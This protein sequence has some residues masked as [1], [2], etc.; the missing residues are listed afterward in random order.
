M[1]YTASSGLQEAIDIARAADCNGY[2][3]FWMSEHHSMPGL[4]ISSPTVM[5]AR[6]IGETTRIRLGAGG[7]MLPNHSPLLVAEEYGMLDALA[8]GRIDLG[9]GRSA[10]PNP[11]AAAALGRKKDANETFPDQISELVGFLNNSF[12][13]GHV[14]EDV[15]AVPG[16]WQAQENRVAASETTPE[17]WL[18]GS[19]TNSARMAAQMGHSYAFAL[20]FGDADIEAAMDVY[21]EEFQPSHALMQPYSMVSVRATIADDEETARREATSSAVAMMRMQTRKSFIVPSPE[22]TQE[23]P[24]TADEQAIID[25]HMSRTLMGTP[26]SVA[27]QIEELQERSGVDE[28]MLVLRSYTPGADARGIELLASHYGMNTK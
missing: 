3:R 21:R 9:L 11:N 28:V 13:A 22:E 12:P 20:Q 23:Y 14:Y 16:P 1:G 4:S 5:I 24:A 19:S 18:L 27:Q 17:L 7:V 8:P 26:E 6:L 25:F 2:H 15:Y 10:G